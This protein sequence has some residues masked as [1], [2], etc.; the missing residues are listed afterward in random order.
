MQV[1][2]AACVEPVFVLEYCFV[3][4]VGSGKY[5][6]LLEEDFMGAGSS[7]EG[8]VFPVS[9]QTAGIRCGEYLPSKGRVYSY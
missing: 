8:L 5:C 9:T 1:A 6:A 2:S 3:G 4:C 7:T